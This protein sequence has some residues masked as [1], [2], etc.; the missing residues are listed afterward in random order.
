[1]LLRSSI[2]SLSLAAIFAL[3]GCPEPE[4]ECVV[5]G[6]ASVLDGWDSRFVGPL[7]NPQA[8]DAY[9]AN[10]RVQVVIQGPGRNL[11]MNPYG[12]N[13]IDAD[14]VRS[15]GSFRDAFGEVAPFINLAG[16]S[17]ASSVT[18]LSDGQCGEPAQVSVEAS[19]ALSNYINLATGIELVLPGA[20][21]DVDLDA[22][23]PLSFTTT[24]TAMPGEDFIRVALTAHN[25]GADPM[26]WVLVWLAEAGLSKGWVPAAEGWNLSQFGAAEYLVF[27]ADEVTYGMVPLLEERVPSR[28]YV[29]LVGG[30]ALAQDLAV[31]EIFGF[32]DS[33]RLIAPGRSLTEEF[34]FVIG[35][36]HAQTVRTIEGLLGAPACTTVRGTVTEEGT[37]ATVADAFV[38][39]LAVD[40]DGADAADLARDR[41]DSNGAFELCLPPGPVRLIAGAEGR[42]YAGGGTTPARTD[43]TVVAS[44]PQDAGALELPPTGAFSAAAVDSTGAAI[45]SR[46]TVYGVDPSPHTYRL[47]GDGFDPRPPGVAA[48]LDSADGTFALALEPGDYDAVFTRGPEY[49]LHRE[50]FTIAAGGEVAL[51]A[52][53]HRV[54][55]TTGYLSGDFH[56]HA[57]DSPDSTITNVDRVTNMAAEG[58]E[59]LV[60]TDHAFVTDYAP[61]VA[62]LGLEAYITTMP[63]QE[64]TTFDYGHFNAFPLEYRA[65]QHNR[66]AFDWPGMSPAELGDALLDEPE[67]RVLQV[68]HPRA[69][70]APGEG[71][72][73][74]NVDL[75]FDGDGPYSGGDALDPLTVRLAADTQM[76]STSFVAIEVM[77]WLD[78]QGLSD[79]FNF[80]NAG[81]PFTGTANSDT[82][83]LFVE[84]SGWPRN[85]VRLEQDD[86]AALPPDDLVLALHGGR[87][88]MS[89]GP[90][91][92][93]SVGDAKVGDTVTGGG[94]ITV[95]VQVQAPPWIPFDDV[96]LI[97]GATQTVLAGGPVV[98]DL[99]SAGDDDAAQR[100]QVEFEH[101]YTPGADTWLVVMASGS[102]G[103]FPGVA[104]NSSDRA[105]LDL[106]AI[107]AGDVAEPATAFAL[108]NPIWVDADGDGDITPSNLVLEQDFQD[109]RWED[110]TNPYR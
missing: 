47:D 86:P 66:G 79:W 56:V 104:Y 49:T 108:T 42:P 15:D 31:L 2:V 68:N 58:V 43:L 27:A 107:R 46:L 38:G 11:A 35:A 14:R 94:E 44:G 99:V 103:L 69:V 62:D 87:N 40:E 51:S 101:T 63:G 24:Y 9:L 18:V 53:L 7:S 65:D 1:M 71:N 6:T 3:G 81:V 4:P 20:L 59:I 102:E 70:P 36:S 82:H 83:T 37:R 76:L 64:I 88:V 33:S 57:Q 67:A 10:D 93:L 45:P 25:N 106:A 5:V 90:F 91:I 17:A 8:G 97:D 21:D 16:T 29:S 30:Y 95:T 22:A 92:R 73:F 100:L 77:T 98:P 48:M 41:T 19:Y 85:Y 26:P 110:R 52:T 72:Y 34:A 39:A 89:F 78:V 28:G 96:I 23:Y 50:E 80:L 74:N 60:S 13:I 55:D 105:T 84:S 75:Q 32:P 109:W 12:G 54:V 61:V